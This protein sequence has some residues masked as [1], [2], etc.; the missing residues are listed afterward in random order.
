MKYESFK[1]YTSPL[2]H[3]YIYREMNALHNE[4]CKS[5]H[6]QE[7]SVSTSYTVSIDQASLGEFLLLEL[8]RAFDSVVSSVEVVHM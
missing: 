2:H 5:E 1:M 3:Y 6:E 8:Q 7:T 4:S